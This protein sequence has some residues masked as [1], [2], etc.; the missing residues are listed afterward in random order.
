MKLADQQLL[1]ELANRIE[2]LENAM[3][4]LEERLQPAPASPGRPVLG[5]N[6][7]NRG[8]ASKTHRR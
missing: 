1:A 8:E 3:A 4:A 7:H 5:L 2:K 6:P